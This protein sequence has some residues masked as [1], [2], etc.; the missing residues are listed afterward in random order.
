[1]SLFDSD[2]SASSEDDGS[3]VAS[4]DV[5]DGALSEWKR[6]EWRVHNFAGLTHANGEA[7][8][9]PSLKAHGIAWQLKVFP[10]GRDHSSL[11]KVSVLVR[12]EPGQGPDRRGVLYKCKLWTKGRYSVRH[13]LGNLSVPGRK[14]SL[15]N[16][17]DR[18]H[19][20]AANNPYL[21]DGSL[22]VQVALQ[23]VG[24]TSEYIKPKS[25]LGADMR[26]LLKSGRSADVTFTIDETSFPAHRNILEFRAPML[27]ELCEDSPPGS[28]VP[29]R[30]VSV[31]IFHT[32]LD[33]VYTNEEPPADFL[34][35]NAR[36]LL[37]AA[38]RF[39]CSSLKLLAESELVQSSVNTE[40]VV[41]LLLLAD[42]KSCALLKETAINY[43]ASDPSSAM[44]SEDWGKV[45]ESPTLMAEIME[46]SFGRKTS[47]KQDGAEYNAMNVSTLRRKLD[48]AGLSGDG[49]RE[50]LVKRLKAHHNE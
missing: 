7:L 48:D 30:G 35:G 12:P 16:H 8:V 39:G 34:A 21:L 41:S 22:V 36:D 11:E 44:A 10:R 26:K 1:M 31:P 27:F 3:V 2:E 5:G 42:S 25:T 18:K 50:I 28:E 19:L 38:D 43:I 40:N 37:D 9:C 15:S 33:H 17:L 13:S 14:A 47:S 29:I 6:V 32:V 20:L 49:T 4:A 24:E 23:V 46:A 45:K